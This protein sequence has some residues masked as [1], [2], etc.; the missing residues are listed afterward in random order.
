MLN[1][2]HI[3]FA[4]QGRPQWIHKSESAFSSRLMVGPFFYRLTDPHLIACVYTQTLLRALVWV[5]FLGSNRHI[6]TQKWRAYNIFLLEFF[7]IV[8]GL[9]LWCRNYIACEQALLF[10]QAKRASRERASE[11][12][13]K[14]ELATISHKFSFPPRKP[15]NSAKRENCHRKSAAD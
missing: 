6:E 5:S 8:V 3:I 13:R 1:S 10:G 14:G 7:P 9:S 11:G 12:P 15:R 2:L 4:S